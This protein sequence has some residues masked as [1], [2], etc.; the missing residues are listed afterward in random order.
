MHTLYSIEGT[1]ALSVHIA[2]EWAEIPYDVIVMNRGDNHQ[3]PYLQINPLGSVPALR[4]PDESVMTE[5][6][7]LLTYIDATLP[8]RFFAPSR[9]RLGRAQLAR[10]LSFFTTE[11]HAAFAPHFAPARFHPDQSEH[12][13][14]KAMAYCRLQRL[15][16]L[17][18]DRLVGPY[19]FGSERSVADPYLYVLT[20]WLSDCPL[21]LDEFPLLSAFRARMD[22]DLGVRRALAMYSQ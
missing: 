14:L 9:D 5:A 4:L 15:F 21:G 16:D 22:I 8:D 17:T 6:A 18:D 12:K 1:C 19:I 7:A 10:V 3:E 20:R 13:T 11:L 2:L